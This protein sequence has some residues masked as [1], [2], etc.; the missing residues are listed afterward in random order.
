[1]DARKLF[2]MAI[3][4]MSVMGLA[5]TAADAQVVT[6]LPVSD[7]D[8]DGSVSVTD[9]VLI[10]QMVKPTLQNGDIDGSGALEITDVIRLVSYLYGGGPEPAPSFCEVEG[11]EPTSTPADDS[12]FGSLFVVST[13]SNGDMDGNGALEITDVIRLAHYLFLGGVEPVE[14]GCELQA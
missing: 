5:G 10:G 12:I 11:S 4:S 8:G 3:V 2:R 6:P 1:M 9:L 13:P 14:I 7:V